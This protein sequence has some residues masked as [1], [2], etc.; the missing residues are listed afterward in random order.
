MLDA[1]L[2]FDS[3]SSYFTTIYRYGDDRK[4][5]YGTDCSETSGWRDW[6]IPANKHTKFRVAQGCGQCKEGNWYGDNTAYYM[7]KLATQSLSFFH[8]ET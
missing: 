7:T 4:A 6:F 3:I 8:T 2:N 1:S 5:L